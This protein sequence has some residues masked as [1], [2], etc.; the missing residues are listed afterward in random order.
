IQLL[1]A[2]T[3]T[4]VIAVDSDERKLD[5]AR[6]LGADIVLHSRNDTANAIKNATNKVGADVILDMVG[7]DATLALGAKALRAEGRLVIVG[8]AGGKL[9][10]DFFSIPYGAQVATS[11]WGTLPELMELVA[12]ARAKKVKL[13]VE[14]YPLSQAIAVYDKLRRGQV[15]GRAVIV[16]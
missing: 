4:R 5:V 2:T 12:L 8:L 3:G 10:V 16:P 15:K 14:A 9:D 13:E 11:Y 7:A 1:K 6:S